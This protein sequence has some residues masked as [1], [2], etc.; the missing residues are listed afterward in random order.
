MINKYQ[1]IL[2]YLFPSFRGHLVDSK[3]LITVFTQ[4]HKWQ[5]VKLVEG[6]RYCKCWNITVYHVAKRTCGKEDEQW[7]I[8][9]N[10]LFWLARWWPT[11]ASRVA[12]V[13]CWWLWETKWNSLLSKLPLEGKQNEICCYQNYHQ[14]CTDY[15]CW[16]DEALWRSS[17]TE[18]F[19]IQ[20]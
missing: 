4:I 2:K 14:P 17:V 13:M 11:A 8:H 9:S 15:D 5:R 19:H 6:F 10:I 12:Q 16:V 3:Y 1:Y 20:L 7:N 18:S